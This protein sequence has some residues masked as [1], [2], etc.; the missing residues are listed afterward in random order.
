MRPEMQPEYFGKSTLSSSPSSAIKILAL[1][2][3]LDYKG[4]GTH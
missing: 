4:A 1:I 3:L 2:L